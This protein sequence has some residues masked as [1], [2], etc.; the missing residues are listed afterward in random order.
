MSEG[1]QRERQLRVLGDG[2]RVV[3][4][5][6]GTGKPRP[7]VP[8]DVGERLGPDER[9]RPRE[10]RGPPGHVDLHR[11]ALV[12]VGL[13]LLEQGPRRRATEDPSDRAQVGTSVEQG[14]PFLD[15][16]RGD[17]GVGVEDQ[18]VLRVHGGQGLVERPGLAAGVAHG[19]HDVRP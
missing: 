3:D 9:G 4:G 5:P 18:D 17:R 1:A 19:L 12:L 10:H 14:E 6:R 11:I 13:E 15:E 16:R 7:T 2:S 8:C